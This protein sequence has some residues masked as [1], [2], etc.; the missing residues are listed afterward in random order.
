MAGD[1]HLLEPWQLVGSQVN[2]VSKTEFSSIIS[3]IAFIS[4]Q[5]FWW[6]LWEN[7]VLFFPPWTEP[8]QPAFPLLL[9]PPHAVL[10]SP[11]AEFL[12]SPQNILPCKGILVFSF[13]SVLQH[14]QQCWV[15][16]KVGTTWCKKWWKNRCWDSNYDRKAPSL[17]QSK[18]DWPQFPLDKPQSCAKIQTNLHKVV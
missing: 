11:E 3:D 15:L 17:W 2:S 13:Q 16:R 9:S 8:N 14:L 6:L 7:Q 4:H 12:Q 18:Q 1:V 5:G 10:S